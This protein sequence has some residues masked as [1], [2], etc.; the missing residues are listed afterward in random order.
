MVRWN[1]Q[2]PRCLVMG[3][4]RQLLRQPADLPLVCSSRQLPKIASS[5]SVDGKRRI[6][7]ATTMPVPALVPKK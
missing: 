7:R 1:L 4:R 6:V 3:W 2:E 5:R